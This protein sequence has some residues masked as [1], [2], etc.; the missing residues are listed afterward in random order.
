MVVL[1]R[2]M[3][4]SNERGQ[5]LDFMDQPLFD[6]EIQ[7]A[8][9]RRRRGPLVAGTQPIQQ[10]VCASWLGAFKNKAKHLPSEVRQPGASL[11]AEDGR[12]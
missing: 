8:V 1:V 11:I 3:D 6:K 4:A 12:M 5:S 2:G 7:G 10:I 9:D